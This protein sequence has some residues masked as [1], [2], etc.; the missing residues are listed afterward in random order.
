[1]DTP[2]LLCEG[3]GHEFDFEYVDKAT[4]ELLL[5]KFADMSAYDFNYEESAIWSPLNPRVY[6][7]TN[8]YL[9]EIKPKKKK[10]QKP[11]PQGKLMRRLF[12]RSSRML[13][14]NSSASSFASAQKAHSWTRLLRVAS[15]CF[16]SGRP[17]L[18]SSS[19]RFLNLPKEISLSEHLH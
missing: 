4:S 3:G 13:P 11:K 5:D 16:K 7:Y 19:L 17:S 14:L 6:N 18:S 10:Q 1:M 2:R 8:T 9:S 15:R 12:K